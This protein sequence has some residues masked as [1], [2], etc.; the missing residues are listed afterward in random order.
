[1]LANDRQH[2]SGAISALQ[3]QA[4]GLVHSL[5]RPRPRPADTMLLLLLLLLLP[6]AAVW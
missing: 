4:D 2:I 3:P 5:L 1:V 6:Q